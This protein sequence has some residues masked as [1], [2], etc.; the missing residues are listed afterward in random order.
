MTNTYWNS[1]GKHQEVYQ[2]TLIDLMPPS[3]PASTVEGEMLRASTKLYYDYYNNGFCNNTSGASNYLKIC[4]SAF[5]LDIAKELLVISNENN[6][7]GY[8]S[9]KL[10]VELEAVANAV[11]EY[12]IARNG[13]YTPHTD[14]MFNY[15]DNDFDSDEWDDF[16][17]EDDE[18]NDPYPYTTDEE[19]E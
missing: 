11:I 7:G 15:Q 17:A 19:F 8:T 12:I 9:A 10:E 14:D 18:E 3:G 4:N 13:A 16:Y 5:K 6:T 2:A 1:T